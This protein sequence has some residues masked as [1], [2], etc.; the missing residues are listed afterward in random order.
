[1]KHVIVVA[2]MILLISACKK[3]SSIDDDNIVDSVKTPSDKTSWWQPKAGMSFDW[4]LDDLQPGASFTS[5]IVDV[6]AFTTSAAQVATLHAQ[7]KKVIAY[8]SVGTIENDRPDV[9]LLPADVIGK[10]YPEWPNERWLNIKK[11]DKLKPWLNSR[12]NMI[13]KK[14]FDA[15]EPD[16]LDSYS[17][18]TGFKI[19]LNDTKLYCDYLIKLAHENGLGIGQKNVQELSVE[20]ST[21]FDWVLTEDA[22]DQGW[23]KDVKSYIDLNKPVFVVEYTDKISEKTFADEVCPASQILKYTAVLKHRNLDKWVFKCK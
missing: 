14:G 1:M 2:M 23:L 10:V 19:T 6:D 20:Y 17:N 8:I 22:F 18:E 7:G 12:I 15:I 11:L 5:E 9:N 13:L 21:K 3:D 4:M 16:D